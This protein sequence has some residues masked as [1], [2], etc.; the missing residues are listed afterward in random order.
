MNKVIGITLVCLLA[1]ICCTGAFAADAAAGKAI[2]AAKCK[3]CHGAE[4]EGNP[5]MAKVLK[6]DLKPLSSTSADVKAVITNGQ[7]KMKPVGGLAGADLDNVVAFVKSL[8]K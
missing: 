1:A 6:V 3:A 2:Y 8:K 4:G 7:G 5:N